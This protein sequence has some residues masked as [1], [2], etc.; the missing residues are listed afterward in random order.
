MDGLL[1]EYDFIPE[2]DFV[3][4]D[5]MYGFRCLNDH[6]LTLYPMWLAYTC[7]TMK[8]TLIMMLNSYFTLYQCRRGFAL[9]IL[10]LL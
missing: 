5:I 9:G 7:E 1:L 6:V 3:V 10:L 2:F 4:G 8:T